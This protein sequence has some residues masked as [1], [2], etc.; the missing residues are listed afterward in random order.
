[1]YALKRQRE[2]MV[3][4][5]QE[6]RLIENFKKLCAIDAASFKER[7]MADEMKRQ[8]LEL[9]FQVEEDHGNDYYHSMAG[10]VYGFLKGSL[11]GEPL[12]FSAHLDTVEPSK[13]KEALVLEDGKIVS[14]GDTVL[15]ADDISGLVEILEAVRG[16]QEDG[17]EHR[18]IEVIFPFAEEAFL[19]GSA[20]FDYSKVKS[21]FSY[22]MDLEG[23]IGTYAVAA[24]TVIAFTLEIKG[25]ASHAGFAPEKGIHGIKIMADII[26]ELKLGVLE[27][28]SRMNIG[29][30]KGGSGRNIIPET[31]IVEGE[32]RSLLPNR[33]EE[34]LAELEERVKAITQ[35]YQTTYTLTY[36]I[37]CK[38]YGKS[39]N[40]K[41]IDRFIKFVKKEN[42]TPKEIHTY[43]GSDLNNFNQHGIE[44]IVIACGMH[45]VHSTEEY[46]RVKDLVTTTKLLY[47]IMTEK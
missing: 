31:C 8:L 7:E 9:G 42:L 37:P 18:D 14:K 34:L 20:V 39:A 22:I 41:E 24:P 35:H 21:K 43:G 2:R 29:T 30:I 23:E 6:K 38:V 28:D 4:M 45:Q 40:Q 19:R 15:G 13:G 44:G 3:H 27:D 47:S 10:N 26:S 11:E 5:I 32:I 16:I 33:A 46:T 1:M 25:K 17:V 36:D 12:L